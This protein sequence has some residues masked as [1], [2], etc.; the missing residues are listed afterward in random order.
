MDNRLDTWIQRGTTAAM[1]ALAALLI[2][3]GV[4]LYV[5]LSHPA[6][7]PAQAQSARR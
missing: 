5:P 1:V 2:A 4:T 7:P 3:V 6:S